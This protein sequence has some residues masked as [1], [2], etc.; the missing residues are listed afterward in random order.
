MPD[1]T[2]L[3]KVFDDQALAYDR[4]RPSY[5][6]Q[7]LDQLFSNC[8][9]K[10]GSTVLEIGCGTGQLT[11]D[12]LERGLQVLAVEKGENLALIAQA[13][14]KNYP[15]ATIQIADFN[16]WSS[17]HSFDLTVCA[18]AFHWF[19]TEKT[20]KKIH[21]FLKPAG[22]LGL[23]WH[24]DRSQDTEFWKASGLI[25]DRYFRPRSNISSPES[26]K[27]AETHLQASENW[28]DPITAFFPWEKW[29]NK[30]EYLGL[31]STFS[32]HMTL[33]EPQ[34]SA[35]FQEIADLID[36]FEAKVL[37]KYVSMYVFARKI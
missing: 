16:E 24:L 19:D 1:Q 36:Q 27:I 8:S 26:Y 30:E 6:S 33:A 13:K 18:Q 3:T 22:S 35:F 21:Q 5:P 4:Y 37:R 34:R 31:L 14:T 10:P 28:T 25:Y 2:A 29:Y 12:L 9:L 15:Q 7:L 20:L 32:G 11:I 17:L 23:L